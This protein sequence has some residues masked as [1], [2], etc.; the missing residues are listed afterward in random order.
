MAEAYSSQSAPSFDG[1]G[2]I[3]LWLLKMKIWCSTKGY[4]DKKGAY[5]MASKL[6]EAAFLVVTR[7]Q[8][9]D[10]DSPEAICKALK[11]EFDKSVLDREL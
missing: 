3:N 10:Q 2:D 5:A 1:Q 7:T 9:K 6:T 8:E 11:A 4:A